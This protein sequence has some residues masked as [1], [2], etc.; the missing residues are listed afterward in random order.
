MVWH[1]DT[2]YHGHIKLCSRVDFYRGERVQLLGGISFTLEGWVWDKE[3]G[4]YTIKSYDNLC[5]PLYSGYGVVNKRGEIIGIV[6]ASD[7]YEDSMY[8]IP[9]DVVS[10]DEGFSEIIGKYCFQ[11]VDEIRSKLIKEDDQVM[12]EDFYFRDGDCKLER[13]EDVNFTDVDGETYFMSGTKS[14]GVSFGIQLSPIVTFT[15][16]VFQCREGKVYC[17]DRVN[18]V[19]NLL[20]TGTEEVYLRMEFKPFV[21]E[22][23]KQGEMGGSIKLEWSDGYT[24]TIPVMD[25]KHFF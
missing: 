2:P 15:G 24:E 18:G 4:T 6:K 10:K 17:L 7:R 3:Y 1:T 13:G 23:K 25:Y 12:I 22:A 20:I 5:S 8:I 19:V 16:Y 11:Y 14:G 9:I 21:E